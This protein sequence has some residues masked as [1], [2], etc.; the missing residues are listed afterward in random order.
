MHEWKDHASSINA[1]LV[2]WDGL[3]RQGF[4][5]HHVAVHSLGHNRGDLGMG[6]LDER[7]VPRLASLQRARE[8][9]IISR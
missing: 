5:K 9:K 7:I 4:A 3:A 1:H 6:K 2:V 8:I